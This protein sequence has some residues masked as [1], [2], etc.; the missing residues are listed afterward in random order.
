MT[1]LYGLHFVFILAL[2]A[3]VGVL[4]FLGRVHDRE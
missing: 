2:L 3:S 4:V 1:V